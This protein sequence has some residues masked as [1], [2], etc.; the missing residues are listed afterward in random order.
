METYSRSGSTNAQAT[1]KGKDLYV[2]YDYTDDSVLAG[3]DRKELDDI[4]A[5]VRRIG[6]EVT[7]VGDDISYFFGVKIGRKSDGTVH[8]TQPHLSDG[9]IKD[10]HHNS[11]SSKTKDTPAAFS[12]ILATFPRAPDFYGHFCYRGFV[13][14]PHLLGE[15]VHKVRPSRRQ[16]LGGPQEGT[17]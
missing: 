17:R 14:K 9:I 11:N 8:L 7:V 10:L 15:E 3:P 12:K 4:I 1:I 13:G 5:Q 2:I 6:L 16:V